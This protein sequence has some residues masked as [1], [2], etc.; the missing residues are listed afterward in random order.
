LASPLYTAVMEWAPT[1]R[2]ESVSEA[3]PPAMVAVPREVVP[4]RNCTVPVAADGDTLAVNVTDC[5]NVDGLALEVSVVVVLTD[6]G[7]IPNAK[8]AVAVS[9][10]AVPVMTGE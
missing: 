8:P 3:E 10:P 6:P 4:S 2:L 1:A 5:P 9:V 7:V